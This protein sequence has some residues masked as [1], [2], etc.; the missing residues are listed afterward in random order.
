MLL[1]CTSTTHTQIYSGT[2]TTLTECEGGLLVGERL[3]SPPS[4]EERSQEC[5]GARVLGGMC[6]RRKVGW[7]ARRG[8]L[9]CRS[10]SPHTLKRGRWTTTVRGPSSG[11]VVPWYLGLTLSGISRLSRWLVVG[12]DVGL[13]RS[14]SAFD[15]PSETN[16]RKTSS[17]ALWAIFDHTCCV[18]GAIGQCRLDLGLGL[19]GSV[20]LGKEK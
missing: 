5:M 3:P 16:D 4:C 20:V 8:R 10:E 12:K 9:T 15:R 2:H 14:G 13:W 6:N 1:F 17:E 18:G 19:R 11:T 7:N